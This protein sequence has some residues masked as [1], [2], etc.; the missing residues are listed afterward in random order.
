M[1][2]AT[3]DIVGPIRNGGIG[4]AYTSLARALADAGH[5]VTILYTLGQHCENGTIADW[6]DDYRQQGIRFVPLPA[7]PG[8]AVFHG[9][10][11]SYAAF[12][13]LN[14]ERFDVVH[15]PEWGGTAFCSVQAKRQGLGLERALLTVGVHSPTLWHDLNDRRTVERF[16]QLERDFL[17]RR[18]VEYADVVVSPSQYLLSWLDEWGWLHSRAITCPAL[19]VAGVGP[20]SPIARRAWREGSWCSSGGSSRERASSSSAMRWRGWRTPAA[21]AG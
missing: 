20:R 2:I 11:D 10:R 17:E 18:S 6:I 8:P 21:S 5:D 3:P 14:G 19:R 12:R 15:F 13:W 1:A 4:T 16:D 7:P 9:P